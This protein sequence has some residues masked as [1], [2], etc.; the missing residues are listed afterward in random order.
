MTEYERLRIFWTMVTVIVAAIAAFIALSQAAFAIYVFWSNNRR[1]KREATIHY[2]NDIR[3]TYRKEYFELNTALEAYPDDN[4]RAEAL[5]DDKVLHEKVAYTLG[6]FEH[7]AIGVHTGVFD[8]ELIARMSGNFFAGIYKEFEYYIDYRR[9]ITN[10]PHIYDEFQK[11]VKR[12][13]DR[14]K[15]KRLPSPP[16]VKSSNGVQQK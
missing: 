10:N 4:A 15:K 2:M 16:A 12:L 8:F 11:L 9:M 3:A 14:R 5:S 1:R 7:L 13:A 6:L